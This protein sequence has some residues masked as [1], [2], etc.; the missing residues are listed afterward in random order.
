MIETV[1]LANAA[2][3]YGCE[4]KLASESCWSKPHNAHE[5]DPPVDPLPGEAGRRFD[6]TDLLGQRMRLNMR[7]TEQVRRHRA[8]IG[9]NIKI[10]V[11]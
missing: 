2:E 11:T 10:T 9:P 7:F 6:S 5:L 4:T 8:P 3:V 1:P